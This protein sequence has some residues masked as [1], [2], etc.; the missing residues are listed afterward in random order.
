MTACVSFPVSPFRCLIDQ[1]VE[2]WIYVVCKLNLC[3]RLHPLRSASNCE[4]HNPLFAQRRVEYSFWTKLGSEI[5]TATEHPPEGD[6]FTKNQRAFIGAERMLE[7]GIDCLEEILTCGGRTLRIGRVGTE[8][9]R[10]M[11]EE[12]MRRVVYWDI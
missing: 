5:H 3:N 11:M 10:T 8:R 9:R 2:S 4:A 1:L 12:R 6:V 7:G